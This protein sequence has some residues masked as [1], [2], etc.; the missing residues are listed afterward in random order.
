MLNKY[1][2]TVVCCVIENGHLYL[3]SMDKRAYGVLKTQKENRPMMPIVSSINSVTSGAEDFLLKLITPI[4]EKCDL[5]TKST[6]EYK[7]NFENFKSQ[8]NPETMKVV[9]FDAKSL[10]TN[11]CSKTVVDHIITEIYKNPKNF[12][13]ETIINERTKRVKKLKIP[14]KT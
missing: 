10:F 12:F 8:F 4:V 14:K 3:Q 11:V 13:K 1:S 2:Y 5:S 6:K 9:S 7:S